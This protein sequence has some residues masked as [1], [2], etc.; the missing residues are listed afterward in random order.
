MKFDVFVSYRR[1]DAFTANLVAEKL[2]NLG[3][4]V[5][6]DVETLR[7]G[8][9]NTQ[10]YDVIQ[11]C[12]DF[13]LVLPPNALDRCVS[14]E[15]W[16]RKEVC[17]A[18]A[19]KKN[20]IPVL[21][22]GFDWPNPMPKGMEELMYYQSI[23]ASNAEYFDMS[24][25]KLSTYLKSKPSVKRKLVKRI[26][27]IAVCIL[28]LILIGIGFWQFT[29]YSVCTDIVDKFSSD[30]TIVDLLY[31]KTHRLN[32]VWEE[33]KTDSRTI[34]SLRSKNATDSMYLSI[35]SSMRAEAKSYN[36]YLLMD[37]VFSQKQI[38][39]CARYNITEADLKATRS[40]TE[41][42]ISIY[43][44]M[45]DFISNNIKTHGATEIN[46]LLVKMQ[47][48]RFYPSCNSF[49]FNYLATL[50]SFPKYTIKKY[51]EFVPN[52]KNFSTDGG[53]H[54]SPD[55]YI[56]AS[57]QEAGKVNTIVSK[58]VAEIEKVKRKLAVDIAQQ[59]SDR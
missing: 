8:N 37:S 44:D 17:H 21:L 20:I 33:Y 5:F 23:S 38:L 19:C 58:Y 52:W 46:D 22:S 34:N 1:S 26:Y 36:D 12:K 7:S 53:V 51:R 11:N 9:F 57:E 39:I 35:I 43:A 24:I 3:Y 13:V 48:E 49:F 55:E 42:L 29:T 10:L 40:Y 59:N 15:D 4:S 31:T 25:K 27:T 41:V 32:E 45:C 6:F 16:I 56:S 18:M 28:A 47:I 14:E 54:L 30:I 2:R 50:S